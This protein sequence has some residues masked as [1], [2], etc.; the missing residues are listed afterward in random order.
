M[1]Y[2]L[3]QLV[4]QRAMGLGQILWEREDVDYWADRRNQRHSWWWWWWWLTWTL[5]KMFSMSTGCRKGC[6]GFR[7]CCGHTHE[8]NRTCVRVTCSSCECIWEKLAVKDTF[9]FRLTDTFLSSSDVTVRDSVNHSTC[10]L[11]RPNGQILRGCGFGSGAWDH[12]ES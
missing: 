5:M 11:Q 4:K 7:K 3:L 1:Q 12:S 2:G 6:S 9:S 8:H 10:T